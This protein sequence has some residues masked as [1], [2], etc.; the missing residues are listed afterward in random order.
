MPTYCYRTPRGKVV[1]KVFP[2]GL[3]PKEI[4]VGKVIAKRDF[5]AEAVGVPATVGWPIECVGS[6]VHA[7]QAGEL[8]SYLRSR[9]VPTE[10]T[11]D[12]NPVY[13]DARHRKRAL[14]ARGMFDKAS[15]S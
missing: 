8:R 3:Q 7:D 4:L 10:V 2:M 11:K 9:G 13:R 15:Y 1:E 6:G 5:A 14:K 12:G